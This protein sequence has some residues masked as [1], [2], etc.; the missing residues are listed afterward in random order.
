MIPK[1]PPP[2]ITFDL[3]PQIPWKKRADRAVRGSTCRRRRSTSF[4]ST[5]LE[6][7]WC[8]S[9]KVTFRHLRVL[10]WFGSE[11]RDPLRLRRFYLLFSKQRISENEEK[12]ADLWAPPLTSQ[13]CRSFMQQKP[14]ED[15]VK[16]HFS[17]N[18]PL[19]VSEEKV[20]RVN[21]MDV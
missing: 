13:T 12:W 10:S 3:F 4:K 18:W 20:T 8:R 2:E 17:P 15:K 5:Q 16:K 21:L 11:R 7:S 9:I 19:N 1:A 6:W 14:L